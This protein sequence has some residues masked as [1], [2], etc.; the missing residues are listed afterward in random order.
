MDKN[1]FHY[2]Q[3]DVI[4]YALVVQLEYI[5][6]SAL[7]TGLKTTWTN[8][9]TITSIFPV[10]TGTVVSLTCNTGYE[11]EGDKEVTCIQNTEFKFTEE[12]ACG[13]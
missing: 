4:S 3:V 8:M 9:R 11:L 6:I 10:A 1:F 2:Q 12:P 7:C 13:G 5:L